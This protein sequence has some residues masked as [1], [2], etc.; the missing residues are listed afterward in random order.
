MPE[1]CAACS[2]PRAS[3]LQHKTADHR[4]VTRCHTPQGGWEPAKQ[5]PSF[6]V[7]MQVK[8]T[9]PTTHTTPG[10]FHPTKRGTSVQLCKNATRETGK[11]PR[12]F[13]FWGGEWAHLRMMLCSELSAQAS[14]QIGMIGQGSGVLTLGCWLGDRHFWPPDLGLICRNIGEGG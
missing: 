11:W 9:Q 13:L 4:A 1:A 8:P 14:K 6:H 7:P 2:A 10:C 5:G 12:F 3:L